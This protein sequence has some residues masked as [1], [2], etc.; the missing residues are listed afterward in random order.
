MFVMTSTHDHNEIK[1]A[2]VFAGNN[3][4]KALLRAERELGTTDVDI[5]E[6]GDGVS[7]DATVGIGCSGEYEQDLT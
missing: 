4:I 2:I 7:V 6:L 3:F 5:F 1:P